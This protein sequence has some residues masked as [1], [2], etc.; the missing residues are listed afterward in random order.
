[1]KIAII[2]DIHDNLVRWEEAAEIIKKE[3]ITIGICCGDVTSLDTLK[4]VAKPF[5]TLH[6]AVGNGDYGIKNAMG[7]IPENVEA[8]GNVGVVKLADKKIAFCH[9]DW[10]AEKLFD[11][12]NYDLIF[13]GHTHTPWERRDGEFLILNPGEIAGQF[14]KASFA[15]LNLDN[16]KSELKLLK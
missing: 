6:L 4:E 7:L 9:Y 2:S 12:R 11:S 14:G 3:K 15:I 16:S 13:Y 5:K 1:M 10:L 8:H